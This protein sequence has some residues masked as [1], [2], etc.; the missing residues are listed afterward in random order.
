M[1]IIPSHELPAAVVAELSAIG[2]RH[3]LARLTAHAPAD[4]YRVPAWY[5]LRGRP[6]AEPA[7]SEQWERVEV[8]AATHPALAAWIAEDE[9][10]DDACDCADRLDREVHAQGAAL[11]AAEVA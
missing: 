8:A 6:C 5:A 7:A 1:D 3:V 11:A 9:R 2:P 10:A 4:V